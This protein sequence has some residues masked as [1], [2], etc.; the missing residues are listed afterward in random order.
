MQAG[1]RLALLLCG[2]VPQ[3]TCCFSLSPCARTPEHR[4]HSGEPSRNVTTSLSEIL[5]QLLTSVVERQ[6]VFC[7]LAF[8]PEAFGLHS[9]EA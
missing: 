3:A 9:W 6:S 5:P 4:S 7:V 1:Y 2:A 8:Q